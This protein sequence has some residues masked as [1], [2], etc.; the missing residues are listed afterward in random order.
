[1]ERSS[2]SQIDQILNQICK[3]H[4]HRARKLFNALG[5]HRGQPRLLELLWEQNGRT[6][7]DLASH[8]HSSP[9]TVTKMLQ[10]MESSGFVERRPDAD[11][12]RISRVYLT[13]KSREVQVAV[14]DLYEDMAR[15]IFEGFTPEELILL[16]RFLVHMRDN[17]HRANYEE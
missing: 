11:D 8:M 3:E 10:R 17:L 13:D 16:R 14:Y 5:L 15:T 2:Q 6:Q 7:S 1:M 9:A 12:Q 4:H